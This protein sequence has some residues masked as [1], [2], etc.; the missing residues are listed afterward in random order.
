M[1]SWVCEHCGDVNSIKQTVCRKCGMRKG[2]SP[3]NYC[4][5]SPTKKHVADR[6]SLEPTLQNGVLYLDVT[7]LH[8]GR[9][10]CYGNVEAKEENLQW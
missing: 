2:D 10:G 1:G 7:C 5:E 9:S 3:E 6:K 4:A 8:C